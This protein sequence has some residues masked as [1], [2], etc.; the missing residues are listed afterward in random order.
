MSQSGNEPSLG[1]AYILFYISGQWTIQYILKWLD[2]DL[3][4]VINNWLVMMLYY[5]VHVIDRKVK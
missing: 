3:D 5:F 1:S 2:Y 4:V